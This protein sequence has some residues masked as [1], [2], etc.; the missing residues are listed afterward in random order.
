MAA[1][2]TAHAEE[3][4]AGLEEWRGLG[5]ARIS[6]LAM[7]SAKIFAWRRAAG[8]KVKIAAAGKSRKAAPKKRRR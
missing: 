4:S 1:K 5:D 3:K 8:Y 6:A 7:L 2:P